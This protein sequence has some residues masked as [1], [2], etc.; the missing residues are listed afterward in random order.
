[1]LWV[2]ILQGTFDHL[3][4]PLVTLQQVHWQ[5]HETREDSANEEEKEKESVTFKC[6]K[7]CG[8]RCGCIKKEKGGSSKGD[9]GDKCGNPFN[10]QECG[11]L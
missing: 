1:M 6:K 4:Q 9:C 3:N 5:L 10:E 2:S 8:P 7:K 11:S